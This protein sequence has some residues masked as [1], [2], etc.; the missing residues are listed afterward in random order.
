MDYYNY[1]GVII[2]QSAASTKTISGTAAVETIVGTA[3]NDAFTN[4]S[5]ADTLMGE[6]GDDLY[7]VQNPL[8]KIIERENAGIDTVK[9][10]FDYVLPDNVQNLTI[11]GTG[12][13]RG[14][15]GIG[16]DLDNLIIGNTYSQTLS[17][18]GGDDVL[19]GGGGNDAF[20]F[21]RNGGHD[22]I[23]DF[24]TGAGAEADTLLI[25]GS[26]LTSF[27]QVKAAMTQVG[28]DVVLKLSGTDDVTFRNTSVDGFTSQNIQLPIDVSKYTLTFDD[29]FNSLS[30][31]TLGKAGTGTWATEYGFAGWGSYVSHYIGNSTGEKQIYVDPTYKGTGTTALGINPFS[32]NDGVLTI[33]ATANTPEQR[34]A[35]F[36]LDFSS[37]LLTT[38]TSFEQT[39]GYFEMR[40]QMP[41]GTGGW[42]A[43]W[44]YSATGSEL[45]ILEVITEK[46]ETIRMTVHDKSL[47]NGAVGGTDFVPTATTAFHTYGLLW[48]AETLTYYI[49]GLA[50]YSLAT[51]ANMHGPMYVLLDL[52]VGG[53]A[54]APDP[55]NLPTGFQVDYVRAYSL[56]SPTVAPL[57]PV[58]PSQST[59]PSTV[60]EAARDV[61]HTVVKS[62][63]F[64]GDGRSDIAWR[65]TGG[66]FTIWNMDLPK[67]AQNSFVGQGVGSDW[68]IAAT[69]DFNG[70]GASDIVWR[71]D[72]GTF[73]IWQAGPQAF[74]PNVVVDTTVAKDWSLAA[75]GDFN[76]DGKDDLIWR[77]ASG[78]FSEWRSNGA[79][80]DKNV[81]VN[82]GVD[83]TWK[84][85]GAFDFNGDGRDD[86]LW[87][88]DAGTLTEWLATDHGFAANTYVNSSMGAD[89]HLLASADFNGDG[90]SDL[91]WRND[92]GEMTTWLSSGADFQVGRLSGVVTSDWQLESSGDFN[93]DGLADLLWRHSGGVFTIW[94]GTDHGFAQ[95]VLVDGSVGV[96]WSM[97]SSDI[98]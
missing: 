1:R 21:G 72:N 28:A 61:V 97:V 41:S 74:Q 77:N 85:A 90:K 55:N 91:L 89:Q 82:G 96:N 86:L 93:G 23:V 7:V 12:P 80:F 63:D 33:T 47:T 79:G 3:G 9:A 18:L 15:A 6:A 49:D 11:F 10:T 8:V 78:V 26:G 27:A 87:R 54:S 25:Q 22:V 51:P 67:I 39:Y 43:F 37:G 13:K 59:T 83:P 40:A 71:N 62:T 32:L 76:G 20:V 16:N 53:L 2:P 29:E 94:Q 58:P 75:V 42:P 19:V 50:V 5:G 66:T 17:G 65:E 45:D 84:L 88:N 68:H 60:S 48:S 44:L 64:N 30:L 4:I 69:A 14:F 52:A 34:A 35:L 46:A 24:T 57:K 92:A 56:D 95:N 70:D 38:R 81:Y 36:G 73:T 98:L 31:Q